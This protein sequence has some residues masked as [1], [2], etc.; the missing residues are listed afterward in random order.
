MVSQFKEEIADNLMQLKANGV[1]IL[2]VSHN[3]EF[4]AAY[5]D[6]CALVFDGNI[7]SVDTPREFFKGKNFYTTAANRMARTR[8]PD[9][10]LTEDII[11]ACGGK[12]EKREIQS[13][14][15][16]LKKQE[17]ISKSEKRQKLT[18]VRIVIGSIFALLFLLTSL[19]LIADIDLR[20]FI[21]VSFLE[22]EIL[23]MI[24]VIEIAIACFCFF[25]QRDIGI[26]VIQLS[27]SDR[28][29]TQRTLISTFLILFLIPLTI[30][31]GSL[32]FGDRKYYFISLLI[33]FETMIPFCM[34]FESR[35]PKAR[36]LIV[37]SVLCAIAVVG[38][39]A[40]FMIPQFKAIAG[41]VI[42]AG[43]CFGGETGFLVGAVSGFVSNFFFGQGPWTPW[44]MFAF[45]IIGFVAGVFFKK[46][47][48]RKTKTSL[49]IFGFLATFI[50]YGGIM[51]PASIIM[52]QDKIT[53]EMI[54]SCYIVGMP[55]DLIH[56]FGT[57][58]FLGIISEPMIEKL[59]RIKIKYGLVER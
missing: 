16:E 31:A 20:G 22:K 47:F 12:V 39:A 59:E 24:A 15:V 54:I 6:R 52:W 34:V 11:L 43:V 32:F 57:A 44:Q 35:K 30:Y 37:I 1:T 55:F 38:R 3:V 45:G 27:K 53:L 17:K 13:R 29:L 51:N 58:F 26:E 19:L 28:K 23:Q 42:I 50:I 40:F 36:E 33:I 14:N 49:C 9:A 41:I 7:T 18:P 2:M 56:A 21:N 46:G 5:A 10:V 48:F 8:L 25:P 4:C